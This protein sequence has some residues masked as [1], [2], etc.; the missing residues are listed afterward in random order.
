MKPLALAFG[1]ALALPAAA[2]EA[3]LCR[4]S[5]LVEP[6]EAFVGQAV[7]YRVRIEQRRDVVDL[8]WEE[9]LSFP[10]LRAEWIPTLTGPGSSEATLGVEERRVL[11]PSR[12]G[13]LALPDELL[14]HGRA[15][16]SPEARAGPRPS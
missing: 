14:R 12:A 10:A 3:P 7:L 4:T 6:A 16:R 15:R 1:L 9:S 2:A 5:V 11:F 8:R 13:R